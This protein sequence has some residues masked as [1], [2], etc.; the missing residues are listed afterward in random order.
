M[1]PFKY[2]LRSLSVRRTGTL[3]TILGTEPG[4]LVQLHLFGL[5]DGL[6]HSLQVSGH[7]LDLIILR[8]GATAET[9]SGFQSANRSRNCH[10]PRH[11]QGRRRLP[12]V[13]P[14]LVFIPVAE[15]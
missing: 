14:E 6:R 4:R 10:A 5:V 11:S 1:I 15:H 3:M 7:P 13:C 8:Q 12:P 2:N 9:T